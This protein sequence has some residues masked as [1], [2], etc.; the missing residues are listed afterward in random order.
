MLSTTE[1]P[2]Q[3]VHRAAL[4]CQCTIRQPRLRFSKIGPPKNG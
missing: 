1:M 4:E 3:E 2:Q